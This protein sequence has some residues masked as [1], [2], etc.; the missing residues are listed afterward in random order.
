[1]IGLVVQNA[2]YI[3][4]HRSDFLNEPFI[5]IGKIRTPIGLRLVIFTNSDISM[6][7]VWD[8]D[9]VEAVSF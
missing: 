3:A 1:M 8:W 5:K 7:M 2:K 4:K 9:K 6:P